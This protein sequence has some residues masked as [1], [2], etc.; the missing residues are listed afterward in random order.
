VATWQQVKNYIYANYQV[1]SDDGSLI[2]LQFQTDNGRSH[3]IH[4]AHIEADQ[5]SSVMFLS[6]VA[7]WT[8]V[9]ADRALRATEQ[10][11][12]A[13]RSTGEYIVAS[14]SQLLSTI[15]EAEIDLPMLLLVNQADQL[16]QLLGLGDQY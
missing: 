11:P 8:Q 15:D 3:V 7:A 13:L 12:V 10:I 16:E 2:M 6:P 9:S 4:L 5:L 14:H 1:S